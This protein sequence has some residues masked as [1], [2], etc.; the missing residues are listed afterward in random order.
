MGGMLVRPGPQFTLG[1][2]VWVEGWVGGC[3]TAQL[4]QGKSGQAPNAI[5]LP[6]TDLSMPSLLP[7]PVGPAAQ[8]GYHDC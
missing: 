1:N 8:Q 2:K 4:M 5:L 3:L 6:Y 7:L